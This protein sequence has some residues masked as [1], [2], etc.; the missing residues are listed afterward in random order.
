MTTSAPHVVVVGA[1]I[2]GLAAALRLAHRGIRVIVLERHSMPGG[3]MRTKPTVAGPVDAGPTVLT[4]KP[5]FEALFADV[6]ERLADHVTMLQEPVLARHFWPD[7]TILDLMKDPGANHAN[8]H[9]AFGARAASEFSAFS[10]RAQK[11]FET[12]DGPMMQSPA[13]SRASL[14]RQVMHQPHLI[15]AMAPHLSLAQTLNRQFSDPRLA[16][17]FARYAVVTLSHAVDFVARLEADPALVADA[18]VGIADLAEASER[19]SGALPIEE[20]PPSLYAEIPSGVP[21]LETFDETG[22]DD[23]PLSPSKEAP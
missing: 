13:P 5:V 18:G 4:L 17:L 20:A 1:G 15:P 7:G 6:G 19:L 23:P 21:T 16:Q 12:F 22:A 11:L 8:V 14:T 10:D 3:K 9:A 2:G